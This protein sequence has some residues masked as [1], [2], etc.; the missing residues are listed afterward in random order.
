MA[1]ESQEAGERRARHRRAAARAHRQLWPV[2]D[3]R[4]VLDR[5]VEARHRRRDGAR[6]GGVEAWA[7]GQPLSVH[8]WV[9]SLADGLVNDL[10]ATVSGPAEA[11][12]T[13]AG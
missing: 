9:S 10:N 2:L 6:A 4:S 5:H 1:C 7:R 8:G 11:G 3:E 12:R 13:G